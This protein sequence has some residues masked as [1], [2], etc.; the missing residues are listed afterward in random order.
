MRKKDPIILEQILKYINKYYQS[1][2]SAPT[3]SDVAEGV[4]VSRST[5]HRYLQEL[6]NR[7]VLT[8]KRGIIRAPESAK[9]RTEYV[10]VPLVGSIR[11]G[12]PEEE[13]EYVEE[14]ISLPVSLFGK[15]DFYILRAKGDS[16]I[17]AGIDEGDLVIIERNCPVSPGDI[18]V[19]LDPDNQNT[20]KRFVGYSEEKEGYILSFENKNCYPGETICLNTLET[21][22]IARHVIK[23][24]G[25]SRMS[26][27]NE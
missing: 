2:R 24:L 8:Y 26:V 12:S 4:N 7:G 20:L 27:Q 3:I 10:S 6:G 15:G 5:A 18:I 11:C 9:L 25:K 23:S 17:D 16:M 21:Q 19:A 14:Y 13:D 1:N 22:G